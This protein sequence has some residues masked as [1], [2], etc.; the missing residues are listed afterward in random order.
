MGQTH[1]DISIH[2]SFGSWGVRAGGYGGHLHKGA[3]VGVRRGGA[4]GEVRGG[5]GDRGRP[6]D[7]ARAGIGGRGDRRSPQARAG[8]GWRRRGAAAGRVH[9]AGDFGVQ[10]QYGCAQAGGHAAYRVRGRASAY[11]ARQ[12]RVVAG[13]V[14]LTPATPVLSCAGPAPGPWVPAPYRVRGR[15]FAGTTV[16]YGGHPHPSPLP[17]RERGTAWRRGW[18]PVCTGTTVGIPAPYQVRGRLFAGMTGDEGEG[19]VWY[20]CGL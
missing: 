9:D 5:G 12:A 20:T 13:Q 15:L 1:V 14:T 11:G 4:G 19:A 16:E 17:S 8:V 10:G 7:T 18:V 3:A 6:D 2:G